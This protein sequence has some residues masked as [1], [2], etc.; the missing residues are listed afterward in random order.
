MKA[1][2]PA[3]LASRRSPDRLELLTVAE[4]CGLLRISRWTFY[5]LIQ[6]GQLQSVTIG[7][8]RRI[9]RRALQR[10]IAQLDGSGELV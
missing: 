4:T 3:S 10:Y 8:S 2:P 5:R 6:S 7:R 9:T 1:S